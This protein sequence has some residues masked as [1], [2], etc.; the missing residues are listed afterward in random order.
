MTAVIIDLSSEFVGLEKQIC[1]AVDTIVLFRLF[2]VLVHLDWIKY[3][4]HV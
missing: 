1:D 4:G 3:S 2:T